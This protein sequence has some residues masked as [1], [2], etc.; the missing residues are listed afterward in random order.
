MTSENGKRVAWGE[1]DHGV[2]EA[3][4]ILGTGFLLS[5][6]DM[7]ALPQVKVSSG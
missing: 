4:H 3:S 2:I 5:P 6:G 1:G 7:V